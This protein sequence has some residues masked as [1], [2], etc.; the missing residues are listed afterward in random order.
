MKA[1]T[2]PPNSPDQIRDNCELHSNVII[3]SIDSLIASGALSFSSIIFFR[4]QSC[5]KLSMT[6]KQEYFGYQ[7]PEIQMSTL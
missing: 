3:V 1:F 7:T 5:F 2:N 4:L 6:T